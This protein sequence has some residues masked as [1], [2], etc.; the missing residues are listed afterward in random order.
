MTGV[1]VGKEKEGG[2]RITVNDKIL[3]HLFD[4][5]RYQERP[6]M[7]REVTQQGIAETVNARRSHVSLALSTLRERGLVEERTVRVTDEVR[8]RKGYSLTSKG[9]EAAKKLVESCQ[10]RTVRIEDAGGVKEI[11]VSELPEILGETYYLVDILCCTNREGTLDVAQLTGQKVETPAP[12][13]PE[14]KLQMPRAAT[15]C[16]NCYVRL[17]FPY[18][19]EGP[20]TVVCGSCG[21]TFRASVGAPSY[22]GVRPTA[23]SVAT[24]ATPP[25][26]TARETQ[27]LVVLGIGTILSGV[28]SL[29]LLLPTPVIALILIFL[30][31]PTVLIAA[32]LFQNPVNRAM[33][34]FGAALLITSPVFLFANWTVVLG[35][36]LQF[37]ASLVLVAAM[38]NMHI[39]SPMMKLAMGDAAALVA[40]VTPL[41]IPWG[42]PIGFALLFAAGAMLA[43]VALSTDAKN[44][45]DRDLM[46]VSGLTAAVGAATYFHGIVISS[47]DTVGLGRLALIVVPLFAFAVLETPVSKRIRA[48]VVSVL[49]VFLM[50]FAMLMVAAP[51]LIGWTPDLAAYVLIFGAGAV[52]VALRIHKLKS[53]WPQI[54]LGVGLFIITVSLATLALKWS[55]MS[56]MWIIAL[57]AWTVVGASL[58]SARFAKEIAER[59]AS[60]RAGT[61]A[62]VGA[63][64]ALAGAYMLLTGLAV[65]GAVEVVLG[66]PLIGYAVLRG[67]GPW[68]SRLAATTTFTVAVALT[69]LAIAQRIL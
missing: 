8:R 53:L 69:W 59:L 35:I 15:D 37:A 57:L 3:V 36:S 63:A 12:A 4:Y 52:Y 49:G 2:F 61:V 22:E 5:A 19:S 51:W 47:W 34:G 16:P 28:A 13:P 7:P 29:S 41:Y 23:Q 32:T 44:D 58:C 39:D 14:P 55:S 10:D 38:A 20:I 66:V 24:A 42:I 60:F 45:R 18:D 40:A 33:S 46:V 43:P 50:A 1:A 54:C 56:Y 30:A 25:R 11:R 26:Y 17:E 27:G 6:E 21:V 9:Y 48:E 68:V 31:L 64:V 65:E 62:A 67:G